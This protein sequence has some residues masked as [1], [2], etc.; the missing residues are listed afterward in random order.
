M[1]LFLISLLLC[2]TCSAQQ[3]LMLQ[4]TSAPVAS[5]GAYNPGTDA[6]V[7]EWLKADA[8]SGATD[9]S[10][11]GTWQ[12][13]AG[14]DALMTLSLLQPVYHI[15]FKNGLPVVAFTNSTSAVFMTNTLSS[16]TQ[17]FAVWLVFK[18][19]SMTPQPVLDGVGSSSRAVILYDTGPVFSAY[20][21]QFADMSSLDNNWHQLYVLFN[22]SSSKWAMDG[23]SQTTFNPGAG[24]FIGFT[25]GNNNNSVNAATSIVGELIIQNVAPANV[26]AI[27]TYLNRWGTMG[28]P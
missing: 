11:F 14:N 3:Q 1:K 19:T 21:T 16:L 10:K 27:F 4:G 5:S 20:S 23:G 6:S 15:N 9:G 22:G 2:L 17:P 26:P 8:I 12:H 25:L 24:A 28:V 18:F 7:V 13:S